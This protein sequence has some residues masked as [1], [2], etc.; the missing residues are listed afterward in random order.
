MKDFFE[1]Y[2]DRINRRGPEDCWEWTGARITAGYGHS[3]RDGQHF[4]AHRAAFECAHGEGAATGL[5]VRHRCDNPPCCN[6]DHLEKGTVADNVHDMQERGRS[7][8]PSGA[9][10]SKAKLTDADVVEMRRLAAAGMPIARI[11]ELYPLKHNT[12]AMAVR[13]ETWSHLPGAVPNPVRAPIP[14]SVPGCGRLLKEED[15]LAIKS[16]LAAGSRGADLARQYCISPVT[17]SAIKVGRIWSHV[18]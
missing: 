11:V 8:P 15:V 7:N 18:P 13:A 2:A 17:I 12:V 10:S 4:Y 1:R 5:V 16:A 3:H 9:R 14:G 6:P